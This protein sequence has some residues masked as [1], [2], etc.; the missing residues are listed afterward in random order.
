[1]NLY[2]HKLRISL[3]MLWCCFQIQSSD[4][5]AVVGFKFARTTVRAGEVVSVL[6]RIEM[7]LAEEK[8]WISKDSMFVGIN[9]LYESDSLNYEPLADAAVLEY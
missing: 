7:P 5:Q 1:M 6:L 4:S 2:S 9:S 8:A 3:A